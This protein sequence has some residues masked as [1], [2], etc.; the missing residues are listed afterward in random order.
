MASPEAKP[1]GALLEKLNVLPKLWLV[2]P[3]K[4]DDE[5][6]DPKPDWPLFDG[7]AGD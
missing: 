1:A 7:V 4:A 5:L 6:A 2:P 3:E